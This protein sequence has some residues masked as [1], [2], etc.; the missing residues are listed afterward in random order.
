MKQ[1]TNQTNKNFEEVKLENLFELKYGSSLPQEKRVVGEYDVYGSNGIVGQHN[2][3]IT[4]GETIIVG[5]KGSIGKINFSN[6][7]CFPIDTTYYIDET[8][9]PCNL[10]WLYFI[11]KKL[12]LESLNRAAAVPGLN[13]KDV[14]LKR[15]LLPQISEQERI[16]KI[17]EKAERLKEQG[18]KAGMLLDEYLKSVFYEMFG[19]PFKNKNNFI[20]KPLK[21]IADFI[22]GRA[23]KPSDWANEGLKIIRIQNLNNSQAKFNYFSGKIEEKNVVNTGDLLFS[24]SG[25][26][27][28]SFGVFIWEGEEAVLN[29]HIFNV[30]I[31]AKVEKIY[32]QYFLN[33]KLSELISKSHGGV[34]L[35]HIT[36]SEVDKVKFILPP[37][38]LQQKFASI[39]KH[40]EKMKENVK[41]TQLNTGDLFNSFIQK[42][43]REELIT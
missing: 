8:K 5:R 10:K 11:L 16:V 31:R 43:F 20:I 40:A 19:D 33:S 26:P 23:F 6:K 36:K 38:P 1:Q 30:K 2:L 21:E 13:R 27:G 29:Q 12:N 42:A 39:V 28:T 18:K 35:Q 3:A 4:K 15:I 7:S 37:L 41:K 14:Y 9:K 32:F 25:T 17:L 22:N 34:G 24:W